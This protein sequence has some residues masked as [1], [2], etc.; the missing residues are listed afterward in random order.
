MKF[1]KAFQSLTPVNW[2][3]DSR[4]LICNS[5]KQVVTCIKCQCKTYFCESKFCHISPLLAS[6]AN[7]HRIQDYFDYF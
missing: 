1:L 5:N 3:S 7:T 6:S 4:V 2:R